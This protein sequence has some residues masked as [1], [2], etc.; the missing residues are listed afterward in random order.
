MNILMIS[1]GFPPINN[2]GAEKFCYDLTKR[3]LKH[4]YF[5]SVAAPVN[6]VKYENIQIFKLNK[7]KNKILRK[8]F[9]D[10]FHPINIINLKKLTQKVN[11]DIIHFHN[12]YGISSQLISW[13]KKRFP[14][15]IT[16]HDYWPIC[17][18]STL[19]KN[20]KLCNLD[21]YNSVSVEN[22]TRI[23]KKKQLQ[24][25]KIVAPSIFLYQL[26]K[27]SG[28]ENIVQIPN[29]ISIPERMSPVSKKLIYVGRISKEKG[30][31][32]LLKFVDDLNVE[33]NIFGDGPL[34]T[35]L[36][37]E[38]RKNKN[39]SFRG[40]VSNIKKI[41]DKGGILVFPSLCAE[42]MPNTLIEAMAYGLP[43][44]ASNL[45]TVPTII[46]NES[47]GL[48]Y[49]PYNKRDFFNKYRRLVTDSNLYTLLRKNARNEA[50]KKYSW[51]IVIKDYMQ[52]YEN[53]KRH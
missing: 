16:V 9:F 19:M 1:S 17:F 45:G 14:T 52:L 18:H 10:Y 38:Y 5:V 44:I 42:N 22:I 39:I 34:L 8:A 31:E 50:K 33:I 28:F 6:K 4:G 51:D 2:Y 15:L 30:I 24:D 46:K 48:L 36:K 47:T 35:K 23:I 11:P 29:G 20:G 25:V 40:F 41:Y 43:I 21:C 12:I 7:V 13:A 3:L 49:N 32:N 27:K 37:T 53:L 26:L